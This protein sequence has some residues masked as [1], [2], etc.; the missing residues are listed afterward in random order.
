MVRLTLQ[1][2][3]SL[4]KKAK[5]KENASAKSFT[6]SV[7][8]NSLLSV[9]SVDKLIGMSSYIDKIQIMEHQ[10]STA[11]HVLNNF[12]HRALLADEVGLG[13][14]IEAG[15]IIKEYIARRLAKKILILVP[16][17]L[18]YQWQEE[19]RSKFSEDFIVAKNPD[20]YKENLKIIVSIDTAKTEKH[21]KVV[22]S[23]NWDLII[24]DEAHKLK[25]SSTQNYKLVKD[26]KKERCLMLTATPL[27]NNMFEL[28]ALLDLL[29]PGFLGTKMKFTKD[30]IDDKEGLHV[31]NKK[32]LQDK[33]GKI[34]VRNLRRDIGITF[35]KRKVKNHFLK[36]NT[37]EMRFYNDVVGFIRRQYQEIQRSEKLSDEEIE[38][39]EMSEEELKSMAARYKQKG[40]L[41]FGLIMLTRQITSSIQ[42]GIV[43]LKRY[44]NNLED[45]NIKDFVEQLIHQGENISEDRKINQL[46]KIIKNEKEKI[47][48][49]TT[50]MHTQKLLEN[51]LIMNGFSIVAFNG[52]MTPIEKE[53][54]IELFRNDKQVLI[55]TDAGSEGRNLQFAHILINF[56][57]PWNPMRI[58]QRIGRVHRIGQKHDVEIHN[59][60]IKDT[61]EGYILNRLYEKINLFTVTIGEMDE[62]LSEL[63]SKGSVE[64][65]VFDFVMNKS[66][67]FEN[68]FSDARKKL[69][70]VKKFDNDIFDMRG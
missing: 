66:E 54:A 7:I 70:N 49:F 19:M 63:K 61:I 30:F 2:L 62:I 42:T 43:A 21:A 41:T 23:I 57:L 5:N 40:L 67:E 15:I 60:A 37:E 51:N 20:D 64:Q 50:F 32:A 58:E 26:I 1:N 69:E 45:E 65:S 18:K 27:Q 9:Q 22:H 17:T 24:I 11:L 59:I 53:K 35:A 29:H 10:T 52:K 25:N 3:D 47:I 12:S 14:T 8:A 33:L 68:D 13:K 28:W 46:L 34:M 48:I 56:D 36:Y 55:C 16:A 38:D 6:L 4:K 39:A 44:K 31:K